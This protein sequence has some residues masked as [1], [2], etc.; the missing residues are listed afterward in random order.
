M[1]ILAA[2]SAGAE[3]GYLSVHTVGVGEQLFVADP[4][5]L[6]PIPCEEGLLGPARTGAGRFAAEHCD[7]VLELVGAACRTAG[8]ASR[9]LAGMRAEVL[10]RERVALLGT[11]VHPMQGLAGAPRAPGGPDGR[12]RPLLAQLT[13]CGLRVRVGMPDDETTIAAFNGMRRWV[14]LLQALAANSPFW[15]GRDS[16]LASARTAIEHT[17]PR[18]GLPRAFR[19]HADFEAMLAELCRVA[20]IDDASSVFWDMRPHPGRGEL[21]VRGLDAQSSLDDLAALVALV[22]CL[23][24][25]EA[26]TAGRAGAS[27]PAPELLAEAQFRAIRDGLEAR[28]S[29]GGPLVAASDLARHAVSIASGYAPALGCAGELDGIERILVEGNGAVRQRRAHAGG[30]MHAVLELLRDETARAA[31]RFGR[32]TA[33]RP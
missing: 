15:H 17:R 25:H 11:G 7:G 16:G 18:S 1:A 27:F 20:E 2:P 32:I 26:L 8:E 13:H 28:I 29:I 3:K 9:G 4:T 24:C 5:E 22:H 10:T 31:V 30:G 6:I 33:A 23:A 21:E 19:D 12:S 14:P